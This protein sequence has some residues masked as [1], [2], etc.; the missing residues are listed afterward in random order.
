[1]KSPLVTKSILSPNYQERTVKITKFT[2]HHVAV[3]GA[4]P[5][6]VAAD[7]ARPERQ[8]SANYII[9]IDGTIIE[10]VPEEKQAWTSSNRTNDNMAITV[11]VCNSKGA[12]NWEVSD[13]SLEALINLAVDICK[14]YNLPGFTYTGDKNGTLTTHNMFANTLCPGP[15]LESKL[16]Y[17]SEEIS[18]RLK[19][20]TPKKTIYRVQVGAFE[21][22]ANAERLLADLKS[23]G[24][25][26]FIVEQEVAV[27]KAPTPAPEPTIEVGSTV[28]V[29]SGAKTYDGRNLAP[30]VYNRDHKVS[31]I[32]GDRAVITYCD[33]V[34]A[35]VKLSDLILVK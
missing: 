35:A 15:Y 33:I 32:N 31:Q 21:N 26:G 9:G 11:E 34:I 6:G 23:K 17:I 16:P 8:A 27:E 30:F 1:M 22:K 25:N 5:E 10:N 28:R 4:T 12:P 20:D 3:A 19:N 29:K 14:R 24:Y 2:P 18:K 7:F 13:E